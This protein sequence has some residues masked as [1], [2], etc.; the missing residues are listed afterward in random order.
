MRWGA[1]ANGNGEIDTFEDEN[2]Q[3]VNGETNGEQKKR[4]NVTL[5]TGRDTHERAPTYTMQ[6]IS[7]L[8]D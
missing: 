1:I 5:K 2:M 4:T 7:A 3:K 8:G 6:S